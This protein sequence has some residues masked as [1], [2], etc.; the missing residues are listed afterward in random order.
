MRV[1]WILYGIV[2]MGRREEKLVRVV[3]WVEDV[4]DRGMEEE[5][6]VGDCVGVG[7]E[8]V[9]GYGDICEG[10]GKEV[11]DEVRNEVEKVEVGGVI[12]EGMREDFEGVEE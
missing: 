10:V 9:G 11:R 2:K 4:E 5:K 12:G 3:L 1:R 6:G 7:R 8:R